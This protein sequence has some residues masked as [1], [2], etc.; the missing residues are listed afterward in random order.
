MKKNIHIIKAL[1]KAINEGDLEAFHKIIG[2][3][4]SSVDEAELAKTSKLSIATIRRVAT[5]SNNNMRT[6]FKVTAAIQS[7]WT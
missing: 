3:Y 2:L 6:L 7:H 1:S 4:I 5:G